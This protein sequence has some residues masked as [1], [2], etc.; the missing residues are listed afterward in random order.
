MVA[1]D[2]IEGTARQQTASVLDA[3]ATQ[4]SILTQT[5]TRLMEQR[6]QWLYFNRNLRVYDGPRTY[7]LKP[8]QRLHWTRT[9]AITDAREIIADSLNSDPSLLAGATV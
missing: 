3:S 4:A 8:L 1:I 7:I 2:L 9:Q 6:A 5:R